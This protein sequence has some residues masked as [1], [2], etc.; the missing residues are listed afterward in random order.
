MRTERVL[1]RINREMVIAIIRGVGPDDILETVSAIKEGGIS[2]ME[3]TFDHGSPEGME[4]TLESIRRVKA[5]FGD[6][7]NVGAGT[8]LS[9]GEVELAAAAGAEYMISP[10]TD[11]SV[12]RRT[13]ELG[14]ISM[15]GALTPS[16]V[17]AAYDSGADMVKMFPAGVLG[18]EYLKAVRAPLSHIPMCAVGGITPENIGLFLAAGIRCFGIGGNLVSPEA[19]RRR[20]FEKLTE[21]AGRYRQ[22]ISRYQTEEMVKHECGK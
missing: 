5:F 12:I 17:C 4:R 21:T 19:I 22:A 20:E 3:V 2:N 11:A 16:E 9:A 6:E 1:E 13:K 15:P 14:K 18:L 8:V 10:G 7:V